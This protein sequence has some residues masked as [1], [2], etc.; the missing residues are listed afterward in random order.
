MVTTIISTDE[1]SVLGGPSK[2]DVSVDFGPQGQRGSQ[3]F[4][5]LGQ[6]NDPST[7]IGFIP[8]ILDLYINILTSDEEYMFI[9]QYQNVAGTYTW[10]KLLKLIPN[11]LSKAVT[12]SFTS[13]E[14]QINIPV[15]S[16]V[17]LSNVSNLTSA[18]FNI[19]H[20]IVNNTNPISSTMTIGEL[21]ITG[22]ESTLPL[23]LK[24]IEFNGTEW[25]DLDG[26]K[27]VHLFITVI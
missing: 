3:I 19:Q 18:N 22:G 5:G 17:P 24:A 11:M 23:T 1:L 13:G 12:D 10:V 9:Y 27:T 2:I 16:I 8:A 20:S 14:L 26:Q 21:A 15:S 6:P 25:I 4:A 7:N